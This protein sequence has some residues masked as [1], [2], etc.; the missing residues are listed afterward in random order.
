V[1][2]RAPDHL[3]DGSRNLYRQLAED[4]ELEREPHALEVLRL[5][6]EA[7]DRCDQAREAIASINCST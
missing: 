6:C 4:Y 7:I 1:A 2:I 5:A 3:S